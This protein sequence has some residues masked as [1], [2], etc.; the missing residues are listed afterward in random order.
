MLHIY[1]YD[2]S[3]LRVNF[4]H[5]SVMESYNLSTSIRY[6]VTDASNRRSKLISWVKQPNI[7]GHRTALRSSESLVAISAD[8]MYISKDLNR[9][10]TQQ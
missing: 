10:T 8:T 1:I 7:P 6:I 2:I 5:S 9:A 4:E 3:N